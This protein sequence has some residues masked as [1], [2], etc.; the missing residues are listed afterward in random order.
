MRRNGYAAMNKDYSDRSYSGV[1]SAIGVPVLLGGTAVGS[2]NLM[3][4][5]NSIDEAG[6]ITRY[7]KPLQEAAAAIAQALNA[8]RAGGGA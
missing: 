3:Y 4:L 8:M 5:R 2:L 1:A 7:I 6:V